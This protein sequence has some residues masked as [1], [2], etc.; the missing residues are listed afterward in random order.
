MSEM[1]GQEKPNRLHIGCGQVALPDWINIDNMPYPG[2][3]RVLDVTLGLPFQDVQYV[4]AEHFIEHLSYDDGINFLRECRRVLRPDGILRLSTPN[5]DW[6]MITHYH[7]GQWENDEQALHDC[8]AT[9]R[10]FRGW[11]HQFL[12]NMQTLTATLRKAGFATVERC[13]Y[14]G[15]NHEVLRGMEKHETWQDTPE[16][17]HVLVIEASGVV[18][19]ED[20]TLEREIGE[21]RQAVDVR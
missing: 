3:D 11:G 16:F 6:V 2:V 17:P 21:Y 15:S 19:V 13:S 8:F 9:N 12:Y 4:F 14:G 5:L 10:A 7:I 1:T 20:D 18:A